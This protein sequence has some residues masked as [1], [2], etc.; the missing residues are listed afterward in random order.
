MLIKAA[1]KQIKALEAFV[2]KTS[3]PLL[4]DGLNPTSESWLALTDQLLK[5]SNECR[6]KAYVGEDERAF[7]ELGSVK[8]QDWI[9]HLHDDDSH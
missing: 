6:E 5:M 7:A 2:T 8:K 3:Y 1:K 9:T 4:F